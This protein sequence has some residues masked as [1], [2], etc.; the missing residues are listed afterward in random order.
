MT[1]P[2]DRLAASLD[3]VYEHMRGAD[4]RIRDLEAENERLRKENRRL[5][6]RIA[7]YEEASELNLDAMDPHMRSGE[8]WGD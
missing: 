5:Q 3:A 6:L 7:E 4:K 1:S 8:D 2:Q